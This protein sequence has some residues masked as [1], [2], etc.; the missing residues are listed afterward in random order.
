MPPVHSSAENLKSPGKKSGILG[1]A[2]VNFKK[3]ISGTIPSEIPEEMDDLTDSLLPPAVKKVPSKSLP[4][5][6]L[7]EGFDPSKFLNPLYKPAG[8]AKKNKS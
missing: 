2:F 1:S 6:T 4:T 8:K 5:D 7:P 3:T